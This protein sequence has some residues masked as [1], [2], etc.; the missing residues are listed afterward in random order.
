MVTK[1][2]PDTSNRPGKSSPATRIPTS[3]GSS[4]A[5]TQ[6]IRRAVS[7]LKEISIYGKKGVRLVDIANAMQLERP[8]VHRMMR[9]LMSQGMVTQDPKSKA[10]RLGPVIYE[11]GLAAT[12]YHNLRELCQP[13]LQNLAN[14]SGDSVFLVVRSGMDI[15]CID[16][17]DGNFM[18]KARTLDIGVRRPMG[19]GAGSLALLLQ[20]PESEIEDIIQA[21]KPRFPLFGTLT[22]QKL[23]AAIELSK[24]AGYAI[25]DEDVMPGVVALGAPII[26]PNGTSYA[27]ISIAGIS[28]R[29]QEPRRDQI[30]RLLLRE[31]RAIARELGNQQVY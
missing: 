17:L 1:K 12:P 15:V 31:T 28:T 18:I 13:F 21:N 9:G 7:I 20:L 10:Y 11:L 3:G 23:R 16:N 24:Q 14:R 6:S 30:A 19:V 4:L 8:T 25:N 22:E 27:A 29:M 5:G 26:N 2:Q